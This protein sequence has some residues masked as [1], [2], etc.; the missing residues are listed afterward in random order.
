MLVISTKT[1]WY[2]YHSPPIQAGIK[3]V[4]KPLDVKNPWM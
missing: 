2:F 1:A 3:R 4:T